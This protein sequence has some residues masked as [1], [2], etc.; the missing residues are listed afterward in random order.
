MHVGNDISWSHGR[1]RTILPVNRRLSAACRALA[2]LHQQSSPVAE[3]AAIARSAAKEIVV[4]KAIAVAF[5]RAFSGPT[6]GTLSQP[7]KKAP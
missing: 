7:K 6:I 1:Q 3:R 5:D 4:S 2:P